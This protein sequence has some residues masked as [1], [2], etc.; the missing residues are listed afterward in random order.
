V[1]H[2][3]RVLALR[4][5]I[6]WLRFNVPPGLHAAFLERDAQVWTAAL[7]RYP[8]FI[9]KETWTE[10]ETNDIIAVIRW[11]HLENWKRIPRSDLEYLDDE[12]GDLL[13]AVVDCKV[14]TTTAE[15]LFVAPRDVL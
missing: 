2:A 14:F 5:V 6:E 9:S 8:G 4:M 3:A 1:T 15:S 7:A 11:T 13:F 12:M 10:T